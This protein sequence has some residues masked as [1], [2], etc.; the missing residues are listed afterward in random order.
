VYFALDLR[1]GNDIVLLHQFLQI[2]SKVK[3][4]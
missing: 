4:Y 1:G 2:S 3:D